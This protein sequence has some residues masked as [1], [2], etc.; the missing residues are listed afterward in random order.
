MNTNI[1]AQFQAWFYRLI[2][3]IQGIEHNYNNNNLI[4]PGIWYDYTKETFVRAKYH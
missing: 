2:K 3:L 1:F 4:V